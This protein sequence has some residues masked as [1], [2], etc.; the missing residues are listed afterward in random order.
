MGNK[1]SVKLDKG[2]K[3][4]EEE[5]FNW[6]EKT[7]MCSPKTSGALE[8]MWRILGQ[9]Q[10]SQFKYHQLKTAESVIACYIK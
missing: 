10:R 6:K 5:D 9:N 3:I 1:L 2:G 8:G 7:V 4:F